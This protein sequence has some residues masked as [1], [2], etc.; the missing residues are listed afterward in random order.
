[1]Q[2]CGRVQ[3]TR[4]RGA[5]RWRAAMANGRWKMENGKDLASVVLVRLGSSLGK[6]PL[7]SFANRPRVAASFATEV[8]E[9]RCVRRAPRMSFS[10]TGAHGFV[11]YGRVALLGRGRHDP[12]CALSGLIEDTAKAMPMTSPRP[13]VPDALLDARE[14]PR[15]AA[16]LMPELAIVSTLVLIA[17][18]IVLVG[19][20]ALAALIKQRPK[21]SS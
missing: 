14:R 9:L 5:R 18:P 19:A 12:A 11:Q 10:A 4:L 17:A 3:S 2:S 13:A 1:M 16:P 15:V 7:P 8:D 6:R 20:T 21:A